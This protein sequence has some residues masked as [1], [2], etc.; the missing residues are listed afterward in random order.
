VIDPTSLER[1]ANSFFFLSLSF[2][3]LSLLSFLS[4]LFFPFFMFFMFF[5][6]FTFF[7]F[8]FM[9]GF[10]TGGSKMLSAKVSFLAPESF[11]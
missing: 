11:E 2:F 9:R 3:L 4:F 6:F 10:M 1:L 5:T 8:F 7:I